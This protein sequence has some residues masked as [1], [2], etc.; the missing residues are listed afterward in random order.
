MPKQIIKV[1]LEVDERKLKEAYKK[2]RPSDFEVPKI[3]DMLQDQFHW[4]QA[5]GIKLKNLHFQG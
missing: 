5:S 3:K 1:V 2:E 4:V